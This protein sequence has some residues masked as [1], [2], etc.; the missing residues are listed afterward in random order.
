MPKRIKWKNEIAD[1]CVLSPVPSQSVSPSLGSSSGSSGGQHYGSSD[2]LGATIISPSSAAR[3]NRMD[4]LGAALRQAGD[5]IEMQIEA[6]RLFLEQRAR[7]DHIMQ[8]Q[9]HRFGGR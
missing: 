8:Q 6:H 7:F 4:E 2:M 9:Q 5:W 1:V 3:S